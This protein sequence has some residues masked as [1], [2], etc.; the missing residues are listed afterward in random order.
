MSYTT[1]D[2]VESVRRRASMPNSQ[3]LFSAQD[4]IDFANDEMANNLIPMIMSAREEYFVADYDY[5]TVVGKAEYRIP[6]R[7]I[8]GKL[9]DIQLIDSGNI[10]TLPRLSLDDMYSTTNGRL[11]FYLKSN[12]VMLSPVPTNQ[13]TLRMVHFRRPGILVP[14]SECG[15]VVDIDRV[16][17]NVTVSLSPT[18]FATG[19]KVDIIKSQAGFECLEIDKE[20]IGISGTVIAFD[21]LPDDLE[22]GDWIALA[23]ESPIPQIPQE[24]FQSLVQCVVVRVLDSQ[25]DERVESAIAQREKML[26]TALNLIT[27][28]VDGASKKIVVKPLLQ[29]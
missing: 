4:L 9:R 3:D 12:M 14:T 24:L 10:K 2:L 17:N 15:Q 8:G 25:G 18:T 16:N 21:S 20:I 7:A 19:I 29:R 5:A 27:P 28:R 23:G 1:S 11:G 13:I 26:E 22:L 6:T